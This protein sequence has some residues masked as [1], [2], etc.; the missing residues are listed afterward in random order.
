[1]SVTENIYI[2]PAMTV[3]RVSV[4]YIVVTIYLI[5]QQMELHLEFLLDNIQHYILCYILM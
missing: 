2:L 1:M 3:C 5:V 4:Q